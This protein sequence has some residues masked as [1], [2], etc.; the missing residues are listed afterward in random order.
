MQG[1]SVGWGDLYNSG[2]A[3]QYLVITGVPDGTYCFVSTADPLST[4]SESD[5]NNNVASRAITLSTGVDGQ[6]QVSAGAPS[7][8]D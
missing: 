7:C 6:R 2:T 5:E 8:N 1:L 3:G 4:L